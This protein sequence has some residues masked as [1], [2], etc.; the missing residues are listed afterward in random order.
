[1]TANEF[2]QLVREVAEPQG[3][4]LI[5]DDGMTIFR[6]EFIDGYLV[7]LRC[8]GS[9]LVWAFSAEHTA[10]PEVARQELEGWIHDMRTA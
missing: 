2:E 10:L 8:K 3:V 1:M 7:N 5:A 9:T 6:D 4:E